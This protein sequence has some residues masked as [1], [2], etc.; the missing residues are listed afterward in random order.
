MRMLQRILR[1]PPCLLPLI[2]MSFLLLGACGGNAVTAVQPVEHAVIPAGG[3]MQPE[4]S[5]DS[6]IST[7]EGS[8]TS[9]LELG[10]F[11]VS[12]LIFAASTIKA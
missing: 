9:P 6:V 1:L 4:Q 7:D 5:P 10:I 2:L 8:R 11:V 12:I 3:G